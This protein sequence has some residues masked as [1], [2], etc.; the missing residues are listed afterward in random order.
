MWE[1]V[2][3]IF[4]NLLPILITRSSCLVSESLSPPSLPTQRRMVQFSA[5][6]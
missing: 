1:S 2:P 5:Q 3:A 4:K 6:T